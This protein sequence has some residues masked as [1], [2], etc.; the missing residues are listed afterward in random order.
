MDC[1]IA[2]EMGVPFISFLPFG[3]T[4]HGVSWL[5]LSVNL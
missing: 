1:L 4:C 2:E 3:D 5:R